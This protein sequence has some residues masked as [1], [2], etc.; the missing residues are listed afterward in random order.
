MISH[1]EPDTSLHCKPTHFPLSFSFMYK[2]TRFPQ[3]LLAPY[4]WIRLTLWAPLHRSHSRCHTEAFPKNTLLGT[5]SK[6][7]LEA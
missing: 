4:S 6:R 7:R 5:F 2:H 1:T 3:A